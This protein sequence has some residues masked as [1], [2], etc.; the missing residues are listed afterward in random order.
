MGFGTFYGYFETKEALLE[1]VA[2]AVFEELGTRNDALTAGIDDPVVVTAISLLS[3]LDAMEHDP[4]WTTLLVRIGASDDPGRWQALSRRMIR[5]VE[6]AAAIGRFPAARVR[7]AP[8]VVG[9]SVMAALRSST[10]HPMSGADRDE[11]MLAVLMAL[12]L[13]DSDARAVLERA[14]QALT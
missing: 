8:F 13:V 14:H 10:E 7:V 11:L 12:G 9:G 4:M 1:A 3:T 2:A 6:S 5:D